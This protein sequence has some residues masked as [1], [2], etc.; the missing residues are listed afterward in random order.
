MREGREGGGKGQARMPGLKS[1]KWWWGGES[2]ESGRSGHPRRVTLML[3]ALLAPAREKRSNTE[4]YAGTMSPHSQLGHL[5]DSKRGFC[6]V[7]TAGVAS[8]VWLQRN[9]ELQ[10]VTTHKSVVVLGW[11]K[12]QS[13][14]W[15][16]V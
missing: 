10:M 7:L 11:I 4:N 2:F 5:R 8:K 9:A 14:E 6:G 16:L 13:E 12:K 3:P 15:W 1:G